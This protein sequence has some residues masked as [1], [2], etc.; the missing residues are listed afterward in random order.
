MIKKNLPLLSVGWYLFTVVFDTRYLHRGS[1]ENSL[2]I[3]VTC[4]QTCNTSG[5]YTF[6]H[7]LMDGFAEFRESHLGRTKNCSLTHDSELTGE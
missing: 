7:D 4:C 1:K 2:C 3:T 6:C 5:N